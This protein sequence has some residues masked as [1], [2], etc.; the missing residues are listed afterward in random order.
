[1]KGRGEGAVVHPEVLPPS[2]TLGVWLSP[3]ASLFFGTS[4]LDDIFPNHRLNTNS[5]GASS[6]RF[7]E[8]K[9][10]VL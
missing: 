1:M 6:A 7:I 4:S 10:S 8:L 9:R 3:R 5:N 2:E